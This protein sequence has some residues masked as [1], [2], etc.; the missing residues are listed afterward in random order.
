MKQSLL[1][2]RKDMDA[3]RI[4]IVV[5][6]VLAFAFAWT[7]LHIRN[8][9]WTDLLIALAGCFLIARVVHADAIPG[10][11]QFWLTRPYNRMSLLSAKLLF[12]LLC[13]SLPLACAQFAVAVRLGYSASQI[14][15]KLL[16]NQLALLGIGALPVLALCSLT[17]SIVIFIVVALAV[18]LVSMAATLFSLFPVSQHSVPQAVDWVRNALAELLLLAIAGVVI[19]RQYRHRATRSSI[20]AGIAGLSVAGAVYMLM[21]AGSVLRVQSWLSAKPGLSSGV[22][23]SAKAGNAFPPVGRSI[24]NV[25]LS[26]VVGHLPP[27]VEVRADDLN[28]SVAWPDQPLRFAQRPGANRR[29]ES[30][31]TAV[32]DVAL[33]VTPELYLAKLDEPLTITGSLYL[34]LFGEDEKRTIS[35]GRG[36]GAAQDGLRCQASRLIDRARPVIPPPGA[37]VTEW[38]SAD[39]LTCTALFLWP[40]RLVYGQAGDHQFEF[41]NT[42]I[43]Y[44]P[45]PARLS[46]APIEARWSEAEDAKDVTIVTRK[47]LDHFRRDFA[48]TG[49]TLRDF[50]RW[51]MPPPPPP[52]PPRRR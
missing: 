33:L 44:S 41:S 10:D 52:P 12:I 8:D 29:P 9:E 36:P 31:G 40:S 32:F 25:P 17:S 2:F 20:V 7:K 39:S 28:I 26:L 30:A 47:P 15:P 3:L 24:M 1:I 6:A 16:F 18:A 51:P 14:A 43:S 34:T 19:L 49:M 37:E 27:N 23:V 22:T 4:E 5:F 21:P 48:V 13:V 45:L 46:F 42:L 11:R 35:L 38:H 50:S